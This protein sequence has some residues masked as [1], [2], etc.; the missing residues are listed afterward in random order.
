MI[1]D[2]VKIRGDRA[3]DDLKIDLQYQYSKITADQSKYRLAAMNK[4]SKIDSKAVNNEELVM[5]DDALVSSSSRGAYVQ[6][7]VWVVVDND[8][9]PKR[10]RKKATI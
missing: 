1:L 8:V 2:T 4:L 3:V 5:D 7:W 6:C 9:K 10:T